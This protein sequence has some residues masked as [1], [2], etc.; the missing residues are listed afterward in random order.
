MPHGY[1]V[2][3]GPTG[4]LLARLALGP[5]GP[6]SVRGHELLLPDGE[7]LVSFDLASGRELNLVEWPGES[8]A[9]V[10]ARRLGIPQRITDRAAHRRER[11]DGEVAEVMEDLRQARL[12]AERLRADAEARVAEAAERARGLEDKAGELE[13]RGER[14]SQPAGEI[15]P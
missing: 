11:R 5:L 8:G 2:R 4:E 14:A 13:R 12:E 9:I 15:C 6:A 1:E 7:G 3:V 10:I